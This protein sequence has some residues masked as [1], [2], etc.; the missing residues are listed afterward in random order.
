MAKH[1]KPIAPGHASVKSTV[2]KTLG[3]KRSNMAIRIFLNMETVDQAPQ[4][5]RVAQ[6]YSGR[7]YYDP[8]TWG[9]ISGLEIGDVLPPTVASLVQE[10][11]VWIFF[12]NSP[13]RDKG[14]YKFKTAT[15]T[16]DRTDS[17]AA[18]SLK[19]LGENWADLQALYFGIRAGKVLPYESWEKSQIEKPPI[20][21]RILSLIR[22]RLSL[23]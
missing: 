5:V 9:F 21:E 16:V 23:A 20:T 6:E 1:I 10:I 13:S 22:R 15:A 3:E 14:R 12:P 18:Y 2:N 11:S 17:T 8:E 7:W 19:M 4:G